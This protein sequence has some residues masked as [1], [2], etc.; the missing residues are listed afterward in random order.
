MEPNSAGFHL[1]RPT[2]DDSQH[3]THNSTPERG[4]RYLFWSVVAAPPI[5]DVDVPWADP[6]PWVSRERMVPSRKIGDA[7]TVLDDSGA[8]YG[9]EV[10]FDQDD[11]GFFGALVGTTD[12]YDHYLDWFGA[13]RLP[14]DPPSELKVVLVADDA[15]FTPISLSEV[16]SQ[17]LVN[18]PILAAEGLTQADADDLVAR[19]GF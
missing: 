15:C 1:L 16:V 5:V 7:S 2:D 18:V 14:G 6:M 4:G 19:L 9:V 12:R 13:L 11:V 10:V 17:G 8:T 3:E